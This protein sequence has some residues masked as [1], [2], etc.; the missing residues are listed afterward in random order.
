MSTGIFVTFEGPEG[1]GK[2]TQIKLL[3]QRLTEQSVPHVL[4]REPGG[5]QV[6]DT[7]RGMLADSPDGS[8]DARTELLLLLAARSH[9]VANVIAPSLTEGKMV[10]CDRY[11]DSTVCYQ[12][13]GRGI[14]RDTIAV[15][16]DY[17]TGG[18]APDL[19]FVMDLD[20]EAGLSRLARSERA[21]D[22]F[23]R[24]QADFHR[25]VREC[26][27][28]LAAAQPGRCVVVPADRPK[29]VIADEIYQALWSAFPTMS[30]DR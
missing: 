8:I 27:L 6:A 30:K 19:T 17:A 5:T 24:E 13:A 16:N 7:L 2:S 9:H 23:E 20:S 28:E 22:R 29:D 14:D 4:T 12:G 10:V 18:L 25:R 1:A 21:L 11:T 26:Y 3:A 15:L